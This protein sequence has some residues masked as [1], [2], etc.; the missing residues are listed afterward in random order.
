MS[1]QYIFSGRPL[2]IA[3][4]NPDPRYVS[5]SHIEL[6]KEL[7]LLAE[8]TISPVKTIDS[9]AD[10]GFDLLVVSAQHVPESEFSK[11]LLGL[12]SRIEVQGNIWVPALIVADVGVKFLREV[13]APAI[14]SNWYFDILAKDH[15]S[16]LP[17]R[18]ANLV[19]I[20]DHLRELRRYAAMIDTLNQRVD[21]LELDTASLTDSG[22]NKE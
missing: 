9:L 11:W 20:H 1:V 8:L 17:V 7:G 3:H 5:I 2:K 22:K 10:E 6:E 16:S 4:W 14:A 21:Q 19:R 12:K 15:I 13:L 18:V